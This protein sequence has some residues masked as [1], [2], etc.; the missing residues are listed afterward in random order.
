[1]CHDDGRT[2]TYRAKVSDVEVAQSIIDL[3]VDEILGGETVPLVD[4]LH[5]LDERR[6]RIADVAT[7]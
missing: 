3:V 1:V 2:F 7:L 4:H 5:R 6:R